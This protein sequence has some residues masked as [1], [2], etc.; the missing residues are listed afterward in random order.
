MERKL[1]SRQTSS[2]KNLSFCAWKPKT[3]L[4]SV[5]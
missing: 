2:R 5:N 3:D 4:T 1:E